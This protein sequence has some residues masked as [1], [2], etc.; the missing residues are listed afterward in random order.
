VQFTRIADEI[1]RDQ[2]L[3][4]LNDYASPLVESIEEHG[5]EGAEVHRRPASLRSFPMKAMPTPCRT[6]ST[7]L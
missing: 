7:P 5:G 4:L 3:G 6:R 2:L 1:E